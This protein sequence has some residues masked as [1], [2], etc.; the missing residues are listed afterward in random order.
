M[1]YKQFYFRLILIVISWLLPQA[2][3]IVSVGGQA[4]SPTWDKPITIKRVTKPGRKSRP[5]PRIERVPPLTFQ[6]RVIKRANGNLQQE[7]SPYTVFHAGDQVKL[8]ITPNQD[9]YL[10][11]IH[12]TEGQDGVLQFPDSRINNGQNYV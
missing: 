6:W 2:V 3:L 8:A 10:Y 7:T 1:R 9:G 5:H 11:I 12:N 4:S